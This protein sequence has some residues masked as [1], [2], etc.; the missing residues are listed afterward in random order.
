MRVLIVEPAREPYM[1][2]IGSELEDLQR[3]VGGY[4][5]A[6]YPFDDAAALICN[7]EGKL[8][9]LEPNRALRG[10][11]GEIYDVIAGTF[12]VAGLEG[13]GFRS[14]TEEQAARYMDMYREPERFFMRG[15]EILAVPK[16]AEPPEPAHEPEYEEVRNGV[17][18]TVERD[19][20][21]ESPRTWGTN[22]GTVVCF[23]RIW[24]GDRH[25]FSCKDEFLK[26]R[27]AAHFKS[28]E[29]ARAFLDRLTGT[30]KVRDDAVMLELGKDHAILPVYLYRHSGDAV[31]TEPFPDRWDS[32]RI[33]WI[34][35]DGD[36]IREYFG[37]V[38][39]FTLP[40]AKELLRNEVG[41]WND[42]IMGENY[43]YD[44]KDER[45]GRV[46]DGGFWTGDI[47]SL[48]AFAFNTAPDLNRHSIREEREAR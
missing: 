34:Y 25:G 27:L 26:D 41:T 1:K 13:D 8:D 38:N 45:T 12:L 33:G 9:G 20:E 35:A 31:S 18:L 42:Y 4:I 39:A 15:G 3:E 40:L 6:L 17:R 37:G 11:Y 29:R 47:E 16:G 36:R 46:L 48:R 32:G 43:V 22:F 14:L 10:A 28:E 21:P 30:E 5:E 23:D 44:L 2:E 7:E 24:Q 19:A